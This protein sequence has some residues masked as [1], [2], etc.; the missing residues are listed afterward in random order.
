MAKEFGIELLNKS[1]WKNELQYM[2][3]RQTDAF[4]N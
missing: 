1:I 4:Q 2:T 3:E